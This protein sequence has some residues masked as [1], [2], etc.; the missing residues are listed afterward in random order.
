MM[1]YA[2]YPG[3]ASQVITK[4]Y[5]SST[6]KVAEMLGIELRE[7]VDANCC[8]A[9]LFN[10]YSRELNLTMSARIFAQAETMGLDILTICNTCLM[11]MS[12]ANKELKDNPEL[13]ESIN[14]NLKKI[15]LNYRGD[16]KITH[17]HWVLVKDFGLKR[18]EQHII[19][20]LHGLKV[21]PYYGCHILRP[22]EV[23]AFEDPENPSSLERLIKTLGAEPVSY[24][25]RLKCCG[26]Q[27]VLATRDTAVDMIGKRLAE[28]KDHGG[29][30]IVTPCPL[31]HINLDTYQGYAE[32]HMGRKI[33]MPVFQV[34]QL[35]GLAMGFT[36]AD[37]A[38]SRHLV[39]PERVLR[40]IGID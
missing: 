29:D 5:L 25:G 3:C 14:K 4:E 22:S 2:Y 12:R 11:V 37:M 33:D 36:P 7:M 28:A 34:A 24:E 39:S 1:R 40:E 6:L 35:V 15:G 23:L 16:V 13:L 38:L 8:G 30:C 10:D 17:L 21:A 27:I 20:P 31:C 19:K 9:G 32:K 18:L 26:F